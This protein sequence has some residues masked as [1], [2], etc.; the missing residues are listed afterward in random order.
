MRPNAIG[1]CVLAL[2]LAAGWV[3][4]PL[5]AQ[6]DWGPRQIATVLLIPAWVLAA[7]ALQAVLAMLFPRWT[8]ATCAA[9]EERRGLCLLWGLL[10][11]LL[12]FAILA[13]SGAIGKWLGAVAAILLLTTG[14]MSV[15]GYV[16]VAAA[17]GARL[18]PS[19]PLR[20]DRTPLQALAGGLTLCLSCLVPILGQMLGLLLFIA[21]VGAAAVVL[22]RRPPLLTAARR[23][24]ET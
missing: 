4:S 7:G 19:D 5:L 8:A 21:G 18:L 14:L 2:S 24:D 9:V 13:V 12:V 10:I 1:P 11:S 16:G 20:D 6:G 17:F 3:A 15:A 22:V 23:A